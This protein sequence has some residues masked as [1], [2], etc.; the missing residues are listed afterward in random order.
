M[1]PVTHAELAN[2]DVTIAKFVLPRLRAFKDTKDASYPADL[3]NHADWLAELDRMIDAWE[4]IL[5]DQA[6]PNMR[7]NLHLFADR[8]G[9]LWL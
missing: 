1:T 8:L 9:D 7:D 4:G 3:G 5:A 2:L 6:R